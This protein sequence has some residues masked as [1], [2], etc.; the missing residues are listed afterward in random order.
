ML[1]YSKILCVSAM[2]LYCSLVAFGNISDYYANF[3]AVAHT[4]SMQELF[5]DSTIGY[6]ALTNPLLHHL[7]FMLAI[8]AE[9]AT[10]ILCMLGAW[11]LF[12]ARKASAQ[13]FN[14]AKNCAIAGLTCGFLTWQVLFMSVGG[15]WFGLWMSA[16]LRG[17]ITVAF[18]IFMTILGVLIYLVMKDE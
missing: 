6:R 7:A 9:S 2:A 3:P 1:R 17:S 12:K 10:A 4:L 16:S 5:A 18:Q 13:V 14:Q 15:E 11:R 8:G